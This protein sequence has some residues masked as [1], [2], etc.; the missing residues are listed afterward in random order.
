MNR[1]RI[2]VVGATGYTGS[3]LVRLLH[4]H[5]RIEIAAITSRSEAGRPFS[6]VHGSL[7][8]I[9]DQKLVTVEDLEGMELDAVFLA[10]PHG[11]SMDY[12]AA[13]PADGPLIIDLSGDFRLPDA[14]EYARW[15]GLEHVARERLAEAVFG[16]PE[17]FRS[18]IREARL[19]ANPGCYPTAAILALG[20]LL[21]RNLVEP[22]SI[23]IDAK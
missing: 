23:V 13:Q 19:V 9:A 5:D 14:G 22:G 18:R 21:K 1:A 4:G 7:Q 10:L 17:L 20:P 11:A 16:L 15:Y 8:G 3:E 6:A 2:A 12:V